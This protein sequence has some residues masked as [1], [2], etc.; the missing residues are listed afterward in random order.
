MCLRRYTHVMEYQMCH[1][2]FVP[3]SRF[4]NMIYQFLQ[5]VYTTASLSHF[6]IIYFE[7]HAAAGIELPNQF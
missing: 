3:W 7:C 6:F 5:M 2:A 4:K 1:C